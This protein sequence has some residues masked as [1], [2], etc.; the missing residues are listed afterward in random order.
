M[1]KQPIDDKKPVLVDKGTGVDLFKKDP[2]PSK[3]ALPKPPTVEPTPPKKENAPEKADVQIGHG[4]SKT[5]PTHKK[6]NSLSSKPN[7]DPFKSSIDHE[8]KPKPETTGARIL[9]EQEKYY[10]S[11][12]EIEKAQYDSLIQKNMKLRGE[13]MDIATQLDSLAGK[14][15]AEQFESLEERYSNQDELGDLKIQLEQQEI[16]LADI[17]TRLQERRKLVGDLLKVS[18]YQEKENQLVYLKKKIKEFSKEKEALE[19]II[20]KQRIDLQHND[21]DDAKKERVVFN[22]QDSKS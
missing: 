20:T 13:I 11:L 4:T 6:E 2:L 5:D 8:Q 1:S 22:H 21:V 18:E 12:S 3:E 15:R 16:Y 17:T 19:K 10:R 14:E 7:L 9:S